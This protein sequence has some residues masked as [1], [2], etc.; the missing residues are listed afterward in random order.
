MRLHTKVFSS[1]ITLFLFLAAGGLSAQSSDVLERNFQVGPGGVLTL[2]AA[3][4]SIEV[5]SGASDQVVV[6]IFRESKWG[7]EDFE[8]ALS[9]F[10]FQFNQFGNDVEVK[11]ERLGDW[12]RGYRRG[13]LR[14]RFQIEVPFQY[15]LNLA[16]AGGSIG[17]SDL[18]GEV[19]AKTAG[20]S[21]TFGSIS[22]RVRGVT[23]GGSIELEGSEA[24][25]ELK[26][27]G[28]SIRVGRV[29]GNVEAKT[30]G[31]SIDVEEVYGD[32]H[33]STSGGSV[34]ARISAQPR[35]ECT[36]KTS[37]GSVTVELAE[38]VSV[39]LDAVTSSGRVNSD[40]AVQAESNS[41]RKNVLKGPVGGGGPRLV[42]R[43]SGGNIELR[44]AGR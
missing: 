36:L 13:G 7:E 26:T 34:H 1:P 11:V 32:I 21:L 8:E 2:S 30:S 20:G 27:A 4:G 17:V 3:M 35:G 28:G 31:G 38:G 37:G 14:F 43:T 5:D 44:R 10:D 22:G 24:D 25:A 12:D 29:A 19:E 40:F 15:N 23:A 42:L 18:E 41:R 16:T 6:R 39:D 9:R 33:A